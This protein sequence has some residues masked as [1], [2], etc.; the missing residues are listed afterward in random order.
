MAYDPNLIR[1]EIKTLLQ[2]ITE[3]AFV[4][5]RR[6]PNIEGYP[7]IIFDITDAESERLTNVQ[8]LR[9]IEFQVYVIVAI[10]NIGAAQAN[11][12]LD[13]ATKK[14]VE[15]LEDVDNQSLTGLVDFTEPVAGPKEEQSSPQGS[16]IW[17]RLD[18]RVKI[19]SSVL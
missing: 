12:I 7:A 11:S 6:N 17:Q 14:V 4:Y 5:D 18:F 19:A 10:E 3:I 15:V 1:A 13:V 8:N 2:T 9:T 16:Q